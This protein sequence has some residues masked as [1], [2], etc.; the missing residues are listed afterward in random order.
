MK[1]FRW[2]ASFLLA[3]QMLC[4]PVHGYAHTVRVFPGAQGKFAD[5]SE[6]KEFVVDDSGRVICGDFD[7][8]EAI[9]LDP[10]SKYYIKGL[11]ESGRDNDNTITSLTFKVKEDTDFVV[12]YG[13]K[14]DTVEYTVNYVDQDGNALANSVTYVGNVGDRPVVAYRYIE[15]YQP[16]AYNLVGT[17]KENAADN[18][19]TFVYTPIVQGEAVLPTTPVTPTTPETPTTTPETPTTTTPVT[20]TTPTTPAADDGTTPTTPAADDGTTPTTPGPAAADE[21]TTPTTPQE[22]AEVVDID[23]PEVPLAGPEEAANPNGQNS[24]FTFNWGYAGGIGL[25]LLI[26]GGLG[27]YA[28]H[29][30]KY[31]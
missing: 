18:K 31:G 7:V 23:D 28:Y 21:G 30:R 19:F 9:Q 24:G 15:G 20:P 16:Q 6:Y 8:Y 12:S 1:R 26:V 5:G 10:S 4:L 11:K 14:G 17:L 13:M 3:L 29:K 25:L 22:P 27:Y 2:I